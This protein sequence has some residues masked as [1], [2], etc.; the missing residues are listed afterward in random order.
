MTVAC[1][2]FILAGNTETVWRFEHTRFPFS[3]AFGGAAILAFLAAEFCDFAFALPRE[4]EGDKTSQFSL[5]WEAA[6]L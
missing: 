4:A 6:E 5:D 3:W 2:A 1:F